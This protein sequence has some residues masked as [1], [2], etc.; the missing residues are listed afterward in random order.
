M[1][2]ENFKKQFDS[3]EDLPFSEA[4]IGKVYGAKLA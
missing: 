3:I 2:E 1:F 4:S